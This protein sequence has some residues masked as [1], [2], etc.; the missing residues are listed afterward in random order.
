M[1]FILTFCP[2]IFL[3]IAAY[4]YF[5]RSG[6]KVPNNNKASDG[7]IPFLERIKLDGDNLNEHQRQQ[8]I[9]AIGGYVQP[10]NGFFDAA[11]VREK[12]RSDVLE[13]VD[14]PRTWKDIPPK[15]SI[16]AYNDR[17]DRI[18]AFPYLGE[19]KYI[20]RLTEE[21]KQHGKIIVAVD[22]DDTISPW[23]LNTQEECDKVIQILQDVQLTGAYIVVFT[24]CNSDRFQE[25]ESYCNSN[26][27]T[28][29]AING[30]V[31]DL[32]YGNN[33]KIYA[34]VFVDDR[35]GLDETLGILKESMYRMRS[36]KTS[37]RLDNPG[38]TEF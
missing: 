11:A 17:I 12:W 22:Y 8:V 34:N 26:G 25:I 7:T 21:W 13:G 29:D 37:I 27:L 5:R 10:P 1:Y 38:S 3:G 36:Y 19:N 35:A 32:P 24:A 15:D 31:I 16:E 23:R 30:N 28:I 14:V 18:G 4:L 20:N 9:V 33:N 2:A 6:K